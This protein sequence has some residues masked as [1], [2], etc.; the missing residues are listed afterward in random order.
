MAQ[1]VKHSILDFGSGHDLMVLGIKP[2]IGL[3]ADSTEP[4]WNFLS[5]SLSV[6]PPLALCLLKQINKHEKIKKI[7]TH[8]YTY[9]CMHTQNI[10][11]KL[12]ELARTKC[13]I[14]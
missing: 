7:N 1:S 10:E 4:A 6:S 5:P 14:I 12:K 13:G 8:T 11:G 2:R 9:A 3:R